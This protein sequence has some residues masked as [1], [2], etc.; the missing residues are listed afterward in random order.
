MLIDE[1]YPGPTCTEPLDILVFVGELLQ[2][3]RDITDERAGYKTRVICL[4][5][6]N[7]V[8]GLESSTG[9]ARDYSTSKHS[10]TIV[11]RL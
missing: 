10:P 6:E 8:C 4:C 1:V 2:R 9:P 3:V 5:I 7:A 11:F